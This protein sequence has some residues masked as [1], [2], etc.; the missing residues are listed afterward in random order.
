MG[1]MKVAVPACAA[2]LAAGFLAPAPTV[3]SNGLYSNPD[4]PEGGIADERGVYYHGFGLLRKHHEWQT[5]RLEL[6]PRVAGIIESGRGALT[7]EFIGLQ[8]YLA[9]RRVHII[10]W[11]ALPDP[12]LSR[13]P[14]HDGWRIGHFARTLPD[15]YFDSVRFGDNRIVDPDLHA[16]YEQIRL[17]TPRPDLGSRA[18]S[19][20]R[21]H[22]PRPVRS[23]SAALCC[24]HAAVA[25]RLFA[26]HCHG[27]PPD[28]QPKGQRRDRA[29]DVRK[30]HDA[31]KFQRPGDRRRQRGNHEHRA[32]VPQP[33]AAAQPR[34]HNSGDAGEIQAE[35][36]RAH[37]KL[38]A[39]EMK[40]SFRTLMADEGGATVHDGRTDHR[41]GRLRADRVR[42]CQNDCEPDDRRGRQRRRESFHAPIVVSAFRRTKA[43]YR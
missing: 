4:V 16:Y 31:G 38:H 26:Q 19:G 5:P 20:N 24:P 37:R 9:G 43:I 33:S 11:L 12:L 8:G 21:G 2:L 25:C 40:R 28:G 39:G 7:L 10:D 15:G 27:R 18:P 36:S 1:R 13:L 22:E 42:R 17:I 34:R 14:C 35:T 3:F 23:A 32:G 30:R 6:M 29:C 41:S